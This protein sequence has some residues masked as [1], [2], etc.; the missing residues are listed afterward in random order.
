[1]NDCDEMG[2]SVNVCCGGDD[3]LSSVV[4][5]V[6]DM[7]VGFEFEVEV[8]E[9]LALDDAASAD[10][11]EGEVPCPKLTGTNKPAGS[12]LIPA[13]AALSIA[14][15][16]SAADAVTLPELALE[17]EPAFCRCCCCC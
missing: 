2:I 6:D 13:L 8:E 9:P 10:A 14:A 16:V 1:M 5:V 7:F 12:L 17:L 15:G 3:K 4:V 11:N